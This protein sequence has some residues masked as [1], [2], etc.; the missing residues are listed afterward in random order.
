VAGVRFE[1]INNGASFEAAIGA[2]GGLKVIESAGC[3]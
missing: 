3:G 1:E 2:P